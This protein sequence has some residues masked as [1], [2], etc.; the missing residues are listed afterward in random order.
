MWG[1]FAEL[2]RPGHCVGTPLLSAVKTAVGRNV[3]RLWLLTTDDHPDAVG[4]SGVSVSS[5]DVDSLAS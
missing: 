1:H 5:A 4:W 2:L 3:L